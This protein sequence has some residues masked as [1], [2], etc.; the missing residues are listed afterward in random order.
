MTPRSHVLRSLGEHVVLQ[1]DAVGH[2]LDA[3]IEQLHHQDQQHGRHHQRLADAVAVR[4]ERD[5]DQ[6]QGEEDF[7]PE[8]VLVPERR[9]I[10]RRASR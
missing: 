7:L 8:S 5:R 9:G 10:A 2:R 1:R 6:H 4:A 3:G